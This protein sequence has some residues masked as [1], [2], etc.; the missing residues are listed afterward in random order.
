MSF[1]YVILALGLVTLVGCS[2]SGPMQTRQ[3]PVNTPAFEPIVLDVVQDGSD[4]VYFKEWATMY[5]EDEPRLWGT[6]FITDNGLYMAAWDRSS[7]EYNLIYR[8]PFEQLKGLSNETVER[9]YW[10][11]SNL[12]MIEDNNG[13]SV[14]FALNGKNAASSIISEHLDN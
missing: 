8:L 7:F 2:S 4:K 13:F 6:F 9:D 10:V 12:L 11:D 1:R 3:G 5:E 14:G